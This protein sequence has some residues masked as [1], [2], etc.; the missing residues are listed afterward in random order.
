MSPYESRK[1]SRTVYSS[2][3]LLF[4]LNYFILVIV[5]PNANVADYSVGLGRV[6]C[7]RGSSGLSFAL[8]KQLLKSDAFVSVF[9]L[10]YAKL[11][12]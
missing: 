7:E 2:T 4:W 10:F 11:C 9:S 1:Y 5:K 8:K 3:K 12:L 6:A